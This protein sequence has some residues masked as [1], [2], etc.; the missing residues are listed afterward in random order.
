M[1]TIT[2]KSNSENKIGMLIKMAKDIGVETYSVRELTDEEMALPGAYPTTEEFEQWLAKDD[3]E[4]YEITQAFVKVK[5]DLE[6][7][8]K[9]KNVLN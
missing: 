4:K 9:K 7:T 1:K 5:S 8:R 3:G 6:K 2:F